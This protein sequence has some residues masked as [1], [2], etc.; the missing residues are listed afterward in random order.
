MRGR[1]WYVTLGFNPGPAQ[2]AVADARQGKGVVYLVIGS[3]GGAVDERA[4]AAAR[5]VEEL[6]RRLGVPVKRL[7]VDPAN[8]AEVVRLHTHMMTH[9]EVRV[10]VGGGMRAVTVYTLL[11]ALMSRKVVAEVKLKELAQG[12]NLEIPQWVT[13]LVTTSEAPGIMK[14]IKALAGGEKPLQEIVEA[15]GF[16]SI[17]ARK[18]LRT[19]K[20]LGLVKR[21]GRAYTLTEKGR[22][23]AKG[24]A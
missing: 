17:T 10:H 9:K 12:L 11:A 19:L 8:P 22:A 2:E 23:V 21:A 13:Y 4:E 6:G 3:L 7:L 16:S 18:Y 1:A 15:T 5:E 20:R 14:V 24:L